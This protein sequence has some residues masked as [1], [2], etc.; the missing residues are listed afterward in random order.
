MNL[1][2][3]LSSVLKPEI[4]NLHVNKHDLRQSAKIKDSIRKKEVD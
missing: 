4:E 3:K 1:D 2:Q